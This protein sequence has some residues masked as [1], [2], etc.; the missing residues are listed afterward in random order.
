MSN[1]EKEFIETSGDIHV[2]RILKRLPGGTW[3]VGDKVHNGT[4][5]DH[6]YNI[7]KMVKYGY[8]KNIDEP[9]DW[10]KELVGKNEHS[11]FVSCGQCGQWAVNFPLDNKCSNCGY[12]KC[13]TYYDAQTIDVLIN[14]IKNQLQNTNR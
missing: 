13:I 9:Y 4:L 11:V 10:Q 14:S 12:E 2:Y 7:L 6:G 3:K 8:I 1:E 5:Y